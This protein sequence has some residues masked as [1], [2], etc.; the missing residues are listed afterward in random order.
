MDAIQDFKAK[1][2]KG[3][4]NVQTSFLFIKQKDGALRMEYEVCMRI[5]LQI[6]FFFAVSSHLISVILYENKGQELGTIK[7]TWLSRNFFMG[8]LNQ[9]NPISEKARLSIADGFE[10]MLSQE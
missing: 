6:F 4:V 3:Q 2:P 9:K 1:F 5:D 10:R 7:N 8:Y